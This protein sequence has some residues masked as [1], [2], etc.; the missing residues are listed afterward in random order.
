MLDRTDSSDESV[1]W[2]EALSARIAQ[3]GSRAASSGMILGEGFEEMVRNQVRNLT[4]RR[5]R[6]VSFLC[7]A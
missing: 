7:E 5:I 6:T 4:E 1:A 3:S 2:F